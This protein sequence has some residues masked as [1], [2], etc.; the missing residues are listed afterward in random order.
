MSV[1]LVSNFRIPEFRPRR[2][3][4]LNH[5]IDLQLAF[6]REFAASQNDQ[7]F[8]ARLSL[9]LVRSLISSTRFDIRR[10]FAEEM[11]RR[12][13]YLLERLGKVKDGRYADFQL[14][15][16]VLIYTPERTVAST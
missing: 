3:A 15:R 1:F 6:A 7:T 16:D 12:G 4:A 2:R 8:D 5:V 13:L 14:P 10:T 9:G 11:L